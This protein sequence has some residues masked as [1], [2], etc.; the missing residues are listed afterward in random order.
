MLQ[1]SLPDRRSPVPRRC[2]C[3]CSWD[4]CCCCWCCCC[5]CRCRESPL[6]FWC[7]ECPSR[8]RRRPSP[9]SASVIVVVVVTWERWPKI[10]MKG[11][12]TFLPLNL[13]LNSAMLSFLAQSP[14]GKSP[15][16]GSF[17]TIPP[18]DSLELKSGRGPEGSISV[19][20]IFHDSIDWSKTLYL[21]L[22]SALLP[23]AKIQKTSPG[24]Q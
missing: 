6:T 11:T 5:D 10:G 1:G 19:Y 12:L 4:C 2:C 17:L 13:F 7:D 22:R 15:L 23:F 20:I 24:R 9:S 3:C 16:P 14:W 21:I 18:A 8:A